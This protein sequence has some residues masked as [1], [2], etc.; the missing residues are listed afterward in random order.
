MESG[1]LLGHVVSRKGL[2]V[3]T[4]KVRAIL[5]LLA[6][7]CVQEVRGFLGCVGYYRRFIEGYS[8]QATSLTELLKKEEEFVWTKRRQKAFEDLKKTLVKAPVLSPPDWNKEFHVIIDASGWCLGAILWQHGEE[9]QEH[10]VYYAN[11][12]MSPVE[13]KYTTTE[14][15]ALAV[16]YACKKFRHYLLEYRI[17]FHTDHDSLKY[18]VNKPDLSGRI[19]RWILLLQEFNYEVIVKP[20]KANSNA[21]FLSR[22]R[23]QEAME[24]ISMEFL[25]E[26]PESGTTRQEEVTVF[27]INR[28][29]RSEYQEIIDYLTE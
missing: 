20:R 21:D 3:D 6:S 16:V 4:D 19:A 22:Q 14:R 12:Q 28:D 8:K 13:K 7:T 25:D 11:R 1:I 18:L 26:F 24:N 5:A 23:G 2:E 15:E 17:V 27:H 29:G 10:P 9:K